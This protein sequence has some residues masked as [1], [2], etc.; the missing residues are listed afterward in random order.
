M[1]IKVNN[2]LSYHFP[3]G[4]EYA[5]LSIGIRTPLLWNDKRNRIVKSNLYIIIID[6]SQGNNG[7]TIDH[8][9]E[10]ESTH[11]CLTDFI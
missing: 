2:A 9:I 1:I 11:G 3:T 4:F 6:I 7:A 5:G 8:K 10:D